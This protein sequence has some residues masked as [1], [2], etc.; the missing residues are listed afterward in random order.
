ME[1]YRETKRATCGFSGYGG[2]SRQDVDIQWTKMIYHGAT[3]HVQT[4]AGQS[5]LFRIKKGYI[6]DGAPSSILHH[7]HGRVTEDLIRRLHGLSYIG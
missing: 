4:A 2:S 3:S 6:R 7:S 5:N 1:V